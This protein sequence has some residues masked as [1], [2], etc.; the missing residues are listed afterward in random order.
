MSISTNER[1]S[2]KR[3]K[4]DVEAIGF[5]LK[6]IDGTVVD[7]TGLTITA[8]TYDIQ[9]KA[10]DETAMA[11]TTVTAADGTIAWQPTAAA[12]RPLHPDLSP[13]PKYP[14]RRHP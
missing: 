3:I 5:T 1:Q 10:V 8:E 4:G 11:V 2:I 6:D 14:R 12:K 9:G 13:V 7:L